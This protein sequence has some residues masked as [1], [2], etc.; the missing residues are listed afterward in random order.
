MKIIETVDLK[1]QYEMGEVFVKALDGVSFHVNEGEFVVILGPSGSGKST[2]LNIVGGMDSPT[3]GDV[4]FTDEHLSGYNDKQLTNYRRTEVGFVFQFYNLM[5]NLTAKENVELATE[6][7][8]DALDID[9]ILED[10]GLADRKDHF[11]SQMSGGEQQRVA[12]ARAVAKN[13]KVLLCDEPTGALDFKTGITI[14]ELLSKINKTYN[15]TV[16]VITHNASIAE[17]ANRVVKMRS[18]KIIENYINDKPI[19][20]E[21][22][23]W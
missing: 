14:L 2:L 13:P 10:V 20:P 11:P 3:E 5:S 17:M 8:E 21:R 4:I 9:K 6:I 1:K 16:V 22:I 23:E 19:S 12:I 18:G 15:K 7:C